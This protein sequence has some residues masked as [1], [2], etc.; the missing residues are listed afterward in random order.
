MSMKLRTDLKDWQ[1]AFEVF[2]KNTKAECSL[3]KAMRKSNYILT[4]LCTGYY[5]LSYVDTDDCG[6]LIPLECIGFL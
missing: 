5:I 4:F 1:I 2:G 3:I 6:W